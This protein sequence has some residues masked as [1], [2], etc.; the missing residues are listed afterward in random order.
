VADVPRELEQRLLQ[1]WR[2]EIEAGAVYELVSRREHD[3]ARA[4]IL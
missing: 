1:A 3:S 4:E 2:G